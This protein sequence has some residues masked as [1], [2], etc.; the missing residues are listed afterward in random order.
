[1]ARWQVVFG[2]V[3]AATVAVGTYKY[4]DSRIPKVLPGKDGIL[5]NGWRVTPVGDHTKVGDMPL[6]M[7]LSPDRKTVVL[8]SVGFSGVHLTSLDAATHQIIEDRK[9]TRVWNGIA[10]SQDGTKL[11]VS[12]GNSGK[13][14]RYGYSAGHM[15]FEKEFTGPKGSFVSGLAIHP[16]D[17]RL[18]ACDM[19]NEKVLVIDPQ[20]MEQTGSVPTLSNPHTAVFG[21][22]NKHLYVSDWGSRAVTVID[23]TKLTAIRDLRV[24]VKPNDMTLGPDGRLFVACS[25]DNTVHVIQTRTVEAAPDKSTPATRIPEGVREILNT[26]LEP[27][28]LEGSTPVGVAVTPDGKR[29]Y[30]VNSDNNDAVV[31]DIS[32]RDQTKVVG[33]IP[34]GW[35]PTAVIATDRDVLLGVGKGLQSRPNAPAQGGKPRATATTATWDYIGECLEGYVSSVPHPDETK[36]AAYTKQVH[37]NTPF[38]MATVTQ[39]AEKSSSVVPDK[40]GVGSP[41]KHVLY[42]VMEN[43]TYDQVFGDLPQGNGD[44]SLVMFGA[45]VTPN[46]RALALRTVLLDNLY[47][48]GEVSVDGHAW[49]DGAMAS[50]ANQR[51]WTS[52]YANHGDITGSDELQLTSGGYL[53]DLASRHGLKVMTYGEGQSG[54][55]GGS[56]VPSAMRGTWKGARDKDKVDGWIKDLND[57]EKKGDLANLMIMSLGEDHTTGTKPG[58]FTPEACVA[59][60][61]VGIGKIVE[62]ASRSKFWPNMAI[63]FIEDDAQAGPDHVDAHRTF[64][65]V[66]SPYVRQGAVDHTLYTTVSMVRTIELLLG[67]PPMTQ[68]DASATPMFSTF[69]KKPTPWQYA[70]LPAQVDL[71]AKNTAKSVGAQASARMDF[72]DYDRAPAGELNRVLWAH[73]KGENTPYP[74]LHSAYSAS[75]E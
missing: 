15:E 4:V 31:A 48:N 16:V 20:T 74:V 61:D 62:A 37:E 75:A 7:V 19:A 38:T 58:T 64:G 47:C 8:T 36:L 30:V 18:F 73:T 49:S 17:G 43:R 72:S 25:G 23:S 22:D 12:G 63:F 3:L 35:Y 68:Y 24:G 70:C 14:M 11:Y 13:V 45:K 39:T 40:V 44:P 27:T 71:E 55:L 21:A 69:K 10:F 56:A 53:W 6:K 9:P 41:I 65:L 2:V 34:T 29:L 5:F 60:N 59:S 52:G 51:Q 46:R 42:V 50:Q 28:T 66:V 33:F 32:D 26:A 1:M 54:Y 67:L 57:A